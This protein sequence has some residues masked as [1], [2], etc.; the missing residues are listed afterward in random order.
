MADRIFNAKFA[1]RASS[2]P[3]R[4][5]PKLTIESVKKEEKKK[6]CCQ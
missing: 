4:N 5:N 3:M 1:N 6:G 2:R